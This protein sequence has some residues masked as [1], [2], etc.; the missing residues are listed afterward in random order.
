VD[1]GA[2]YTVVAQGL[3]DV[4]IGYSAYGRT[5]FGAAGISEMSELNYADAGI[6]LPS[7]GVVASL[8]TIE[9][10]PDLI[11]RFNAATAKSWIEARENPRAAVEQMASMVPLMKGKEDVNTIEFEAYLKSLDSP[12]T[13]GKPF[14]WQSAQ[15]WKQAEEILIEYMGVKRQPSVDVY[16]T[17][18]FVAR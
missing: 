9:S 3:A 7:H 8:K 17:N 4:T 14:G 1:C 6:R 12:G 16:F 5:M 2:K 11:R 15:E 13:R 10:K 18:E